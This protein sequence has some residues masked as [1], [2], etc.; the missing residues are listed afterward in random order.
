MNVDEFLHLRGT[1]LPS[2]VSRVD[3][4]IGLGDDDVLLAVGS[5]AEGLGNAKSD[6]DLLLITPRDEAALP[7]R[8][9][10]GLVVGKCLVD[11]RVMRTPEVDQLLGRLRTWTEGSWDV[12]HA[13]KLT[14]DERTLLHRLLHGRLLNAPRGGLAAATRPS[15]MD[16]SRLKLQVARQ[17]A[18]TIQVDLVGYRESGD[19][20]LL[21]FAA[22]NLLG[23]AVDALTASYQLTHP[24]AK[25]RFRMLESAP[26]RLGARA[27]ASIHGAGRRSGVLAP[28]P[29]ARAARRAA[30]A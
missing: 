8:D 13:V 2:V 3:T 12:T 25:W 18:R 29:R 27:R 15:Q 17:E 20:R 19:Y 9:E 30:R 21:V 4:A 6:I 22:Q 26:L 28:P 24:V 11:V 1:D 16:L 5:I 10:L 23:Q 14:I 7:S